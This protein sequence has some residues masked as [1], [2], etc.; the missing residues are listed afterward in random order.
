MRAR[1]PRSET[2]SN[3]HTYKI[4]TG[5]TAEMSALPD[6]N[7]KLQLSYSYLK[8]SIGWSLDARAAG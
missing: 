1:R 5:S 7:L 4:D 8:A 3:S 6:F 2:S